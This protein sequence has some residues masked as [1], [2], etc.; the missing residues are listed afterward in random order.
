MADLIVIGKF[1]KNSPGAPKN[2]VRKSIE[3]YNPENGDCVAEIFQ[4][5]NK[6]VSLNVFNPTGELLA[7]GMSTDTH[8]LDFL[9]YQFPI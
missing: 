4:P 5:S 2:S 8:N 6:I 7:S 9:T 3:L 1:P